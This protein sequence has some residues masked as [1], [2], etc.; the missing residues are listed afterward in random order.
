[1]TITARHALVTGGSR[2]I[3]RG[4]ALK[5]ADHGVH[6]AINYLKDEA[7]AKAT[8]EQVRSRGADGFT[9]QADVSQPVQVERLFGRVRSEFG[10]LDIFVANARPELG[11]FYQPPMSIGLDQWDAAMSS[12]AKAFLLGVQE[13]EKLMPDNGRIIAITYAP[14]GRFGSW[15]SWV[16]MGAAKSALE[17]LCRYFAVALAP[18]GITVNTI[19][20]GWI[21]DSVLNTLPEP[22]VQMI[23]DHHRNGWTPM[24][25]LGTPADIGNAVTLLCSNEAGWITGQLI[26]VDGGMGLMDPGLPLAIQQPELQ[27]QTV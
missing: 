10:S 6:V 13:A 8:L 20:P 25:R 3:G 23:R 11:A 18:R 9:V 12:Q 5:L 17:T 26:A 22:V 2:G 24:R 27:A 21:E 7:S 16:G 1:M 14:G 15:Q 4:I 19:S